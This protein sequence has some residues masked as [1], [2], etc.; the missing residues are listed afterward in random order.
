MY[1][2][3]LRGSTS[4]PFEQRLGLGAAVGLDDAHDDIGAGLELGMGALQHLIGLAD[5]GGGADKDLQP[6]GLIALPPRRLQQRFRRGPHVGVLALI[7]HRG[8]IV[9]AWGRA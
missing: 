5:A 2:I 4:R 3:R 9:T 6:A 8:N 7:C 1:S